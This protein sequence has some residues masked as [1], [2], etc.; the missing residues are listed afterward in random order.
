MVKIAV[1]ICTYSE[2]RGLDRLLAQIEGHVDKTIV[3]HGPF[4]HFGMQDPRSIDD[5]RKVCSHYSNVHLIDIPEPTHENERRE[6]YLL[7]MHDYDFCITLDS[8]EYIIDADWDLLRTNC[9]QIKDS[10][11][12]FWLYNIRY[13]DVHHA[14][15]GEFPRLF[16]RPSEIRYYQK[17]YWFMLPTGVIAAGCADSRKTITGIKIKHDKAHRSQ[18]RN[19]GMYA[20]QKWLLNHDSQFVITS[21]QKII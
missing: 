4:P 9:E 10:N 14:N 13:I 15:S 16:H 12:P 6:T 20:H 7:L 11:K 1:G 17:H 5:T 19:E 18:E 21:K 2:S 8:D 3:V